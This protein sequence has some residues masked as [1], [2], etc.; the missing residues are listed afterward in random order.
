[1]NQSTTSELRIER[2]GSETDRQVPGERRSILTAP[3]T[4]PLAKHPA[5][6]RESIAFTGTVLM[7]DGRSRERHTTPTTRLCCAR[8]EQPGGGSIPQV[9]T[10][11]VLMKVLLNLLLFAGLAVSLAACGGTLPTQTAVS[12]DAAPQ[13]CPSDPE[14]PCGGGGGGGSGGPTTPPSAQY[15]VV[16]NLYIDT[17]RVGA[18][19]D[20]RLIFKAST[21]FE[22]Y[23]NGSWRRRDTTSL[24]IACFVTTREGVTYLRDRE[25]EYGASKVDL[26]FEVVFR[27][28]LPASVS[29]T[30]AANSGQYQ[31][32]SGPLAYSF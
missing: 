15:R 20:V 27:Y 10:S 9:A 14:S 25:T 16:P 26:T 23:I 4:T 28:P 11:E 13:S 1:V 6:K 5:G 7:V 17:R 3:L 22:A 30:H 29:C 2:C 19:G 12:G 32:T 8:R 31:A 24:D 21:V 18:D